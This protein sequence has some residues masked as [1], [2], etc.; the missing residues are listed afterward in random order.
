MTAIFCMAMFSTTM[1]Q[2]TPA[3]GDYFYNDG[4]WSS[5][6]DSSK[7]CIGIVFASGEQPGDEVK[8]YGKKFAGKSIKGYVVALENVKEYAKAPFYAT[9]EAKRYPAG[10]EKVNWKTY[11]GYTKT[12]KLFKSEEFKND[13]K[14]YRCLRNFNGWNKANP[15]P[16]NTSGWYIPSPAQMWASVA[17]CVNEKNKNERLSKAY[18]E[19]AKAYSPEQRAFFYFSSELNTNSAPVGM[20]VNTSA[21]KVAKKNALTAKERGLI[22]AVLTIIQ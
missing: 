17:G 1:A 16:E 7:T 19:H 6:Y 22:R 18:E 21:N 5:D 10:E 11:N 4:T 20:V 15:T 14:S 8:N 2:D 3:V 9:E 12:R 13:R